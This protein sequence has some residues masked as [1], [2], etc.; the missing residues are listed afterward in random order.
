[1]LQ[2]AIIDDHPT[3]SK[4]S[5]AQ[6]ILIIH[7]SDILSSGVIVGVDSQSSES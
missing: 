7:E 4:T 3:P 5:T 6:G 2:R 1:M